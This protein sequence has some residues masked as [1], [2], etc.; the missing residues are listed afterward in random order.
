MGEEDEEGEN[1]RYVFWRGWRSLYIGRGTTKFVATSRPTCFR[2]T[3]QLRQRSK[4][5]KDQAMRWQKRSN[6]LQLSKDQ[7]V[8]SRSCGHNPG[9]RRQRARQSRCSSSLTAL[10]RSLPTKSKNLEFSTQSDLFYNILC[11]SFIILHYLIH[12]IF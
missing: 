10:P 12:N 6:V 4:I 3:S 1:E 7:A 5:S 8:L 9:W 11:F 2:S